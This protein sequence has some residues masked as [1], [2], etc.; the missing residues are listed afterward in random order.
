MS[1]GGLREWG[2]ARTGNCENRERRV[3]SSMRESNLG[4]SIYR[5]RR[6]LPFDGAHFAVWGM[7]LMADRDE[8]LARGRDG[9]T[10]WSG[11]SGYFSCCC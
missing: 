3:L 8:G 7:V 6:I 10:A 5:L 2:L 1:K 11:V 4:C 9:E